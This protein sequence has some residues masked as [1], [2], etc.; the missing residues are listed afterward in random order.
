MFLCYKTLKG[1]YLRRNGRIYREMN[2]VW[3]N[4]QSLDELYTHRV[5][6]RETMKRKLFDFDNFSVLTENFVLN[7][8]SQALW[9]S[10]NDGVSIACALIFFSSLTHTKGIL[11]IWHNF[12][13]NKKNLENTQNFVSFSKSSFFSF[14][15]TLK[16]Q[17]ESFTKTQKNSEIF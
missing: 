3:R 5:G 9:T 10:E 16:T 15:W 17:L 1:P 7:H 12:T 11:H 14:E 2:M 4:H 6:Y 13:R 8:M